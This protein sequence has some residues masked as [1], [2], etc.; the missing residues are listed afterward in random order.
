[1]PNYNGPWNWS[2]GEPVTYGPN[3]A[4]GEPNNLGSTP[5]AVNLYEMTSPYPTKWN[6]TQQADVLEAIAETTSGVDFWQAVAGDGSLYANLLDVTNGSHIIY[7]ATGV[8]QA[9]QYQ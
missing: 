3:W 9:S 5:F 7:S 4:P 6:N 8:L 2:S 1:G